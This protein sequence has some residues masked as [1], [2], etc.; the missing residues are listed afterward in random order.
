MTAVVVLAGCSDLGVQFGR[1]SGG[2]ANA[3]GPRPWPYKQGT[4]EAL[5]PTWINPAEIYRRNYVVWQAEHQTFAQAV[6][7]NT[8]GREASYTRLTNAL[9]AMGEQLVSDDETA[10]LNKQLKR[11]ERLNHDASRGNANRAVVRSIEDVRQ[12]V[13]RSF[14]PAVIEVRAPKLTENRDEGTLTANDRVGPLAN[15]ITGAAGSAAPGATVVKPDP[16]GAGTVAPVSDPPAREPSPTEAAAGSAPA[17]DPVAWKNAV[18]QW[19]QAHDAFAAS[20]GNPDEAERAYASLETALATL[21]TAMPSDC[22]PRLQI[23]INEYRRLHERLAKGEESFELKRQ[24]GLTRREMA[25]VVAAPQPGP[26]NAE[27]KK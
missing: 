2:V 14:E 5:D 23:Y 15:P 12:T 1:G 3:K 27:D 4:R 13:V 17:M 26:Q 16:A 24:L 21:K 11:Y 20:V 9:R 8:L 6:S 18:S 7:N 22:A 25:S 19:E 10:I